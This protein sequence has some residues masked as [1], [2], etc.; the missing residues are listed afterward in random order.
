MRGRYPAGWEYLDQ[1][2]AS[3][4]AKERFQVTVQ[5][6]TGACRVQE[7]C[8]RLGLGTSRLEQVRHEI[9]AAALAGAERQRPGR[10]PRR[11]SELEQE[12]GQ[13]RRQVVQ[14]QAA[15]EVATIRA[16]VAATLPRVGA[17]AEKKTT[18]P[19]RRRTRGRLKS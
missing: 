4:E 14:L 9:V 19:R 16:E 13:L 15:L 11:V 10:K 3:D 12:V 17:S 5:I 18:R 1:F 8:A 7:A 2:D 6:L